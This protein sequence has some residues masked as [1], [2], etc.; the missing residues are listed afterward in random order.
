MK[1]KIAILGSTGS[2]GKSLINIIK[3][4]K[5]KFQVILL[6]ANNNDKLLLKQ[7]KELKVKNIII[8]N[9]SKFKKI[10]KKKYDLNI[11]NDFTKLNKI[12]NR[13]IDYIM[14]AITGIEGLEPTYM[15]IKHTKKIAIANKE[16]IICAWN[17]L[18]KELNK[19]NTSFVPVDS[20]HFSIWST[21]N[22]NLKKIL[23]KFT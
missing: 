13:K 8:T 22:N 17:L 1:K 18:E 3:K 23:I 4:K 12:F 2:I 16:S 20:E 10:D 19:H 6:T 7:A 14:S 5:D 21:I 15:S 11:Y 9:E